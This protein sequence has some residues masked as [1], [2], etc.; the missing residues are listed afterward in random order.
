M[1]AKSA[2][3][4]IL[5]KSPSDIVIVSALRTPI[6]RAKK[7][8]LKDVYPEE[9]LSKVLSATVKK[10]GIDKNLVDDVLVGAVL[11]TLGGHKAS[12]LAVKSVGFPISTTTNTINRQC[13]SSAQAMSYIASSIRSGDI[14][15]GIA[16][17]VESMTFDYFPHRGIPT[18]ISESLKASA[19][20]EAKNV[21]MPMGITSENVAEKYGITREEQDHFAYLSH[22]RAARATESGH[23]AKEIVPVEARFV[24]EN[25]VESPNTVTVSKDDGIR[26]TISLDK[27]ATLKPVFSETGTTTAGNSSQISDGASA[28]LL[29]TRAKAHEL[30]LR[31]V[32]R[33]IAS[34]AAG[35]PSALMGIG[36]AAAIPKLLERVGLVS[37]DIDVWEINEAFASQSV[38]CVKE[39]GLDSDKV[40]PNGGAIALGHPLGA[41]GGRL[42]ATLNNDLHS[43]DGELGVLSMCM[44]TGQGYA[45]LLSRE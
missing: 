42:V 8:G 40:N 32:A 2:V 3:R 13:G 27:L 14:D 43:L 24:D 29:M 41:T 35:V 7:G 12:A 25:G 36:P 9:L 33:F 6:T 28:V 1:A 15:I 37:S 34:K 17:G 26:A 10:S 22:T 18:R 44:S 5:E 19:S 4:S 16:A 23:F 11:Q 31:P 39:L 38:Y 30:G 45:A 20:D 21:L